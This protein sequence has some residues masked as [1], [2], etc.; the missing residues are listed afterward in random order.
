MPI[1]TGEILANAKYLKAFFKNIVIIIKM[2]T[3]TKAD[4]LPL[5]RIISENCQFICASSEV[6]LNA[7]APG[8]VVIGFCWSKS[9]LKKGKSIEILTVEKTTVSTLNKIQYNVSRL[10]G[11]KYLA[12]ARIFGYWFVC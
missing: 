6:M 9:I 2:Q 4:S 10:Y 1:L 7:Q 8:G 12:K 3:T 11:C 5:V